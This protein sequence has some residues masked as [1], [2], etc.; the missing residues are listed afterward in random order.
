MFTRKNLLKA[1]GL[2][3]AIAVVSAG[4]AF[5][6]VATGTVNVRTGPSTGYQVIDQ[7]HRGES[8]AI[9]DR[10]GS[11]CAVQK[12]GPD[13]WVSC[14]YLTNGSVIIRKPSVSI[15]F[16]FGSPRGYYPRPPRHHDWDNND[17]D[18]NDGGHWSGPGRYDDGGYWT[19]PRS[20][21]MFSIN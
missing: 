21:G 2:G 16:G 13:G 20:S 12:S 5:A 4:S 18:N 7:L 1:V 14:A 8:V 3:A 15:Q 19:G 17:W 10:A 6:A 11:W 9:V